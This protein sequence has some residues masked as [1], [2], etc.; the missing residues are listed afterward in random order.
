[1]PRKKIVSQRTKTEDEFYVAPKEL[2][3][4]FRKYFESSKKPEKRVISEA[5]GKML[6]KIA[7]RYASK[8]C[9]NRYYYKDEF[10]SDGV[11][12]MLQQLHR[13]DLNHPKCNPFSYLTCICYCAF[14]NTIKKHNVQ[15]A[16]LKAI[17]E[18]VY[19][20]FC[21]R[22]GIAQAKNDNIS[23]NPDDY[24]PEDME[25]LTNKLNSSDEE[26]DE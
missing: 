16:K 3:A 8:S 24:T 17:Q 23:D 18:R 1:M 4:E 2:N 13:I 12:K 19:E 26:S 5:L 6:W 15:D 20:D 11:Y 7:V 14:V 9:F 21:N 22:E 10:I 25:E